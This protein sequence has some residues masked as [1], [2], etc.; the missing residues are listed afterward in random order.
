MFFVVYFFNNL[1]IWQIP[2]VIWCVTKRNYADP[3]YAKQKTKMDTSFSISVLWLTGWFMLFEV[4]L[5]VDNRFF[6][7]TMPF[8]VKCL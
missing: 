7:V 3:I 1:F 6:G 5:W 4:L 8:Y 2:S